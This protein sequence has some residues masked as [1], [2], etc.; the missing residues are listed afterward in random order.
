MLR[1]SVYP[2]CESGRADWGCR[3]PPRG[4][5]K[6]SSPLHVTVW[7]NLLAGNAVESQSGSVTIIPDYRRHDDK[8]VIK[9]TGR[10]TDRRARIK[11]LTISNETKTPFHLLASV[12]FSCVFSLDL[13]ADL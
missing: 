12:L 4:E 7:R 9:D 13:L 8:T 11:C 3:T 5:A 6:Q 2:I 1:A 10:Q